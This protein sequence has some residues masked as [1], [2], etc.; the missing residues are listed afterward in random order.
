MEEASWAA[1]RPQNLFPSGH[2]RLFS[3]RPCRAIAGKRV[4]RAR[5]PGHLV[6]WTQSRG[7]EPNRKPPPAFRRLMGTKGP[8]LVPLPQAISAD[9]GAHGAGSGN[10]LSL[11]GPKELLTEGSGREDG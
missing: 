9:T 2:F 3:P 11:W 4:R 7:C 10:L 6:F 8:A 5:V 1:Q